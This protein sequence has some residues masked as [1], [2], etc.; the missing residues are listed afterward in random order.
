MSKPVD[1]LTESEDEVFVKEDVRN[2]VPQYSKERVSNSFL[3][4]KEALQYSKPYCTIFSNNDVI[5]KV[6]KNNTEVIIS[7]DLNPALPVEFGH[8]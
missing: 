3:T 6:S 2:S 4:A 8:L 1:P 7:L 5:T